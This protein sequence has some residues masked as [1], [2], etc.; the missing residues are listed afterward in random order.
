[1]RSKQTDLPRRAALAMVC[2]MLVYALFW[3]ALFVL[4]TFDLAQ[5]DVFGRSIHDMVNHSHP[6]IIW[7]TQ[8]AL[9]GLIMTIL[10][11]L[12][13]RFYAILAMA[14]VVSCHFAIWP[15]AASNPYTDGLLGYFVILLEGL[16]LIALIHMASH[17]AL[18]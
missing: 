2:A 7:L 6:A 5:F 11:L 3:E 14:V 1:M 16:T 13:S 9:V 8:I 17:K 4:V 15:L 12:R 10:G 18:R